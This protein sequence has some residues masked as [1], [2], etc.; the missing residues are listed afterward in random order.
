MSTI[1]YLN[2]EFLPQE[3]A[4]ISVMD[5][6]FLFGDGVYEVIPIFKDKLFHPTAHLQRLQRSLT[7]I[8]IPFTVN[9]QEL[10]AIFDELRA[11]NPKSTASQAIYLEITR[12]A[13]QNRSH[14]FPAHIQPTVFIYIFNIAS[15]NSA[16][17]RGG[18]NAITLD[19]IRWQW[20]YI[21]SLNLLPNVLFAER[22]KK[23]GAAEAILIRDGM[24]MEGTSSNLFIAKNQVIIT[25][26][27]NEFILPGITRD[28]VLEL[29][30]KHQIPYVEAPIS[31]QALFEADEVWM[32]GSV[33]EILPIIQ[34]DEYIIG[35]GKTGVLCNT[36]IDLYEQN[37]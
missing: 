25:P 5:R 1:V 4:H 22:A 31:K 37:K 18:A 32:T 27:T 33:K 10:T 11:K 14:V 24:A 26:P 29:A 3:A 8:E 20:C 15:K 2:G 7:A 36:L 34:I 21:K 12:G 28:L 23:S 30:A 13:E 19:D 6:G 9:E 17:M 35:S 16:E